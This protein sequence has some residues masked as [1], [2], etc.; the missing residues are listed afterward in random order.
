MKCCSIIIDGVLFVRGVTYCSTRIMSAE[1][2]V[3]R[4]KWNVKK[5]SFETYETYET[6]KHSIKSLTFKVLLLVLW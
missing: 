6:L 1:K 3:D 5:E 2:Q 4:F